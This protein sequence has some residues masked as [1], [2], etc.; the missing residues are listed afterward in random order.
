MICLKLSHFINDWLYNLIKIDNPEIMELEDSIYMFDCFK[1]KITDLFL[2]HFSGFY[3]DVSLQLS[4][5][6]KM[7]LKK[8]QSLKIRAIQLNLL[9]S[10][11]KELS[12][13][14]L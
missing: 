9:E 5:A 13:C 4:M 7:P 14:K 2:F 8:N 10:S 1:T 6:S 12:R 11:Y 3:L